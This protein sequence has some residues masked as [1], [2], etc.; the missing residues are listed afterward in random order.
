MGR[1]L[2]GPG[3]LMGTHLAMAHA[4]AL[5]LLVR[6][7]IP[8]RRT[9]RLAATSE[10]AGGKGLGLRALA[11]NHLEHITS[12]IALAW[13][14][15]SWTGSGGAPCSFLTTGEKGVL[16]M[17]LRSEGD[18][19]RAGV[20]TGKD[21]VEQLAVALS[22]LCGYDFPP[23]PSDASQALVQSIVPT[24][25][26][27]GLRE[28]LDGLNRQATVDRSLR[29][30]E[31][32][33]RMDAGLL[34]LLK[35]AL[36]T[37]RNVMRISA[38][39]PDGLR[40]SVAEAEVNYSFPPG[41]DAE[42]VAR[43]VAELL[44]SDGVYLSEKSITE[45]SA[46]EVVPEALAL[47]RAALHEVDPDAF[48]VVGLAPWPTGLGALRRY[49]TCVLGWEPFAIGGTLSETLSRRGGIGEMLD[50]EDFAREIRAFY[51]YLVRAAG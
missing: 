8:L 3:A 40:P 46:S 24:I 50:M 14:A 31:Q 26:D 11:E 23:R 15:I 9:V 21:P 51:S 45:P 27:C 33:T 18:G 4:M 28:L 41:E 17:K 30:L 5:V 44:K 43:E 6:T 49:G 47:A 20:R 39:A 36:R 13:G 25:P 35:A 10:G 16:Q 42:A 12:D 22:R 37:E 34:I 38:T 48:L 1:S 7:G 32:E 19:G 29:A 2:T